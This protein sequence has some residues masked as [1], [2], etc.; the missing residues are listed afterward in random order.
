M[1]PAPSREYLPWY[2]LG[3]QYVL[4]G[5]AAYLSDGTAWQIAL[6]LVGA[7]AAWSWVHHLRRSRAILDTPTSRIASSAQGYAEMLGNAR[8]I[9]NQPLLSPL[10]GL[11]CVWYRYL[12][13]R[14]VNDH[15]EFDSEGVSDTPFLLD[16]GTGLC[17]IDPA[18]AEILSSHRERRRVGDRRYIEW[19]LLEGDLLYALGDFSTAG[20]AHANLDAEADYQQ[21]LTAWK[22]DPKGLQERFD[23]DGN[24]EIDA[25]EWALAR[26]AAK[27]EVG[28][29][30]GQLRDVPAQHYLN[31]PA[32][33][34][35]YVLS[36][37][38]PESMGRTHARWSHIQLAILLAA[39][40]G[41]AFSISAQ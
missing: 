21:V 40:V 29:Q 35:P 19:L 31:K 5:G 18:G 34:R 4:L 36:N 6:L 3:A 8:A 28:R 22:A 26:A 24:G 20:G 9:S 33:G 10:S 32:S 1:L 12:L 37:L 23:F 38:S 16:D 14:R 17:Q 7:L 15:W 27:R 11:P 2:V 13:Y 25:Q 39:C 30:H 41:L